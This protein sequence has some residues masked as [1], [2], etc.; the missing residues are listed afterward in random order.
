MSVLKQEIS[1][2]KNP[3]ERR[4]YESVDERSISKIIHCKVSLKR[5]LVLA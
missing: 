1:I 5:K 2:E 4:V 3:H